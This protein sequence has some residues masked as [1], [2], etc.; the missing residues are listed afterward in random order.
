VLQR[1]GLN[2]GNRLTCSLIFGS[3]TFFVLFFCFDVFL[4]V[5]FLVIF[6]SSVWLYFFWFCSVLALLHLCLCF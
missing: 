1:R 6:L 4:N 3:C 5:A 2:S